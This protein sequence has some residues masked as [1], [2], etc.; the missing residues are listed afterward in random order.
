VLSGC[1][2]YFDV[3]L[4]SGYSNVLLCFFAAAAAVSPTL[5]WWTL[6]AVLVCCFVCV[7]RAG[8]LCE[9]MVVHTHTHTHIHTYIHT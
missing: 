3:G 5:I 1:F 4:W 2:W 6:W 7:S 8:L 9:S